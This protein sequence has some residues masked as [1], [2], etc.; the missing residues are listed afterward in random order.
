MLT[1]DSV[2]W[3]IALAAAVAAF[4]LGHFDL[5][6]RA[7]PFVTSVWQARIELVAAVAGFLAG[8]LKMSPLR[9][10]SDSPLAGTADPARTLNPFKSP[11]H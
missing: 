6:T 2:L 4:L 1:R 10:R 3:T 8:W 7:F 9:L 11:E 5:L